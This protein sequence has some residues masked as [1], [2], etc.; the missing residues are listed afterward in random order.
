MARRRNGPG[1]IPCS[2][3]KEAEDGSSRFAISG[4][5]GSRSSCACDS[6]FVG[7]LQVHSADQKALWQLTLGD[8]VACYRDTVSV[9][10]HGDVFS[11]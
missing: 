9:T 11:G 3:F 5:A 2:S 8:L 1:R 4:E 7:V 10:K 6:L